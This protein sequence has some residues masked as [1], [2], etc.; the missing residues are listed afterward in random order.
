[1]KDWRLFRVIVVA[2]LLA[3]IALLYMI[4]QKDF[5]QIKDSNATEVQ[6]QQI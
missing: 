4:Y 3:I 5:V 6:L 1:M 2:L